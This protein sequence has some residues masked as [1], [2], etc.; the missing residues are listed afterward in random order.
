MKDPKTR[1]RHL[2]VNVDVKGPVSYRQYCDLQLRDSPKK[3]AVAH[4]HGPL[5]AG[6]RTVNWKLP[7]QAH[8]T[9]GDRP[10][11]LFA[12]IGTMN[13]EHGCWVVVR[14]HEG[15]RC[16]FAKGVRPVVDVEFP[17]KAPGGGRV[18]KRYELGQ[19][20]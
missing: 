16:V 6:P 12:V 10:N 7:S 3:A 13:A 15:D 5:T 17:A 2:F 4:F 18:K 14:T 8:L 11:E 1:R 20:C 19:F 9:A